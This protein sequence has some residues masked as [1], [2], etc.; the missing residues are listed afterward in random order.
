M[1]SD[2]LGRH[3]IV[4][5]LHVE[6]LG[7]IVTCEDP[8]SRQRLLAKE[9]FLPRHLTEAARQELSF[10]FR[11][12]LCALD[13]AKCSR[14]AGVVGRAEGPG[15]Y[16]AV[17]EL[18]EGEALNLVLRR[19][20][21]LPVALSMQL[22]RDCAEAL[23][24]LQGNGVG[25]SSVD[26]RCVYIT[27]AGRA[28]WVE[29]GFAHYLR[30]AGDAG[31]GNGDGHAW[32][33]SP[34]ELRRETTTDASL[35]FSLGSLLYRLLCGAA[36]TGC[37]DRRDPVWQH[38]SEATAGLE[39]V[40]NRALAEDPAERFPNAEAFHAA[41]APFSSP[42]PERATPAAPSR[43][44]PVSPASPFR[45]RRSAIVAGLACALT[46]S[47]I[48]ALWHG[49]RRASTGQPVTVQRVS[50]ETPTRPVAAPSPAVGPTRVVPVSAAPVVASPPERLPAIRYQQ[51]AR[52]ETVLLPVARPREPHPK[53][54]VTEPRPAPGVGR[55]AAREGG[56]QRARSR[57]RRP[58]P[59]SERV[60]R[61]LPAST[62]PAKEPTSTPTSLAQQPTVETTE[63][64][65]LPPGVKKRF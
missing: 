3:R 44:P 50:E 61:P 55:Q 52:T 30:E 13:E 33:R 1:T 63:H 22:V 21:P 8:D 9:L 43:A 54:G 2:C 57:A 53:L 19:E 60:A 36:Q 26:P 4:E 34:E 5:Q 40:V 25:P 62:S 58:R 39:A 42:S 37:A 11:L 23:A 29:L 51:R 56:A 38:A 15:Q 59:T 45:W 46:A 20:R 35:V 17:F 49:G 6:P 27:G 31:A 65:G 41:F 18:P 47:G 48:V 28:R 10:N 24:V 64:T 14:L 16:Y 7:R 12:A 32:L